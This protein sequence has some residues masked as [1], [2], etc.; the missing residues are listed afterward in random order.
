MKKSLLLKIWMSSLEGLKLLLELGILHEVSRR[1][2]IFEL[3]KKDGFYSSK[4]GIQIYQKAWIRIQIQRITD[5]KYCGQSLYK[6]PLCL[7]FL[8]SG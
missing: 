4:Y 7:G 5:H 8:A 1:K 3:R 6:V 2:K